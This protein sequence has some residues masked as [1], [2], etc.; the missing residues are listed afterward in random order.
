MYTGSRLRNKL[1]LKTANS[2]VMPSLNNGQRKNTIGR[3]QTSESQR[4]V[5]AAMNVPQSIISRLWEQHRQHGST[6]DRPKFGRPRV[7]T[8]THDHFIRLRHLRERFT[9]ATSTAL[10]IPG[11]CRFSDKILR[12]RMRDA[13]VRTR[14]P[15]RPSY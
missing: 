10:A 14:Q 3:L 8:A 7:T 4:A 6:Y 1:R 11:Q 2:E 5:A 13:G 15:V 12:N 9:T